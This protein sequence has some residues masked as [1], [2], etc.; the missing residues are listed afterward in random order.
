MA[1][2]IKTFDNDYFKLKKRKQRTF[3]GKKY[4]TRKKYRGQ[5]R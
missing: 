2:K 3:G 5:G 1:R 4:A